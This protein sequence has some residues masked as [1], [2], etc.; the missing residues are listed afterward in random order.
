MKASA[1]RRTRMVVGAASASTRR[2]PE[3]GR[4]SK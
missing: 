2:S 4:Q 3:E 1:A